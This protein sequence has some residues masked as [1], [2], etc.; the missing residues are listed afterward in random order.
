MF[1]TDHNSDASVVAIAPPCAHS[2]R[3]QAL[4]SITRI[5]NRNTSSFR[6][7]PNVIK[8]RHITISNRNNK[9]GRYAACSDQIRTTRSAR[10]LCRPR[11]ISNRHFL[12]RLESSVTSRKQSPAVIS[13]RHFWEG[14][15]HFSHLL[16]ASEPAPI[17]TRYTKDNRIPAD[18]F[19]TNASLHFYS[20]QMDAFRNGPLPCVDPL[21]RLTYNEICAAQ[22]RL[23]SIRPLKSN[24]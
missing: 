15:S 21:S 23:R 20:V 2:A 10:N 6:I 8:T 17:P 13:N 11:A 12:L 1:S 3:I 4:S 5:S 19:K 18:P 9:P 24:V 7:C 22:I 16:R 14:V